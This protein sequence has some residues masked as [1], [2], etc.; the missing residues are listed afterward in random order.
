MSL[1]VACFN[2]WNSILHSKFISKKTSTNT[3]EMN[4]L[5]SGKT[6][7]LH[8]LLEAKPCFTELKCKEFHRLTA[9]PWNLILVCKLVCLFP[10]RSVKLCP[11]DFGDK[12]GKESYKEILTWGISMVWISVVLFLLSPLL[13]FKSVG[14]FISGSSK[15][16]SVC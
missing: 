10:F 14:V 3:E 6:E 16:E 13:K 8:L 2:C 11:R 15:V 1:K 9:F 7:F 12:E 4:R 5:Y